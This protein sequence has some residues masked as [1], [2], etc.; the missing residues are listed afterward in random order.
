M[1]IHLPFK[2][3]TTDTRWTTLAME[4]QS[5]YSWSSKERSQVSCYNVMRMC[6]DPL[7]HICVTTITTQRS[8]MSPYVIVDPPLKKNR[9]TFIKWSRNKPKSKDSLKDTGGMFKAPLHM[10]ISNDQ[11]PEILQVRGLLEH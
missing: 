10:V 4:N 6:D 9:S 3:S 7:P 5:S 11:L 2:T 1:S 8:I